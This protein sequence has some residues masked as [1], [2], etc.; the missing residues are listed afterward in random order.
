[1]VKQRLEKDFAEVLKRSPN[2]WFQKFYH[3]M[4]LYTTVPADYIVLSNSYSVLVECKECRGSAFVFDRLTQLSSLKHFISQG[5]TF[6]SYVLICFWRKNRKSS[7]YWCVPISAM[8]KFIDD[9]GKKSANANDF[10]AL[11][12]QYSIKLDDISYIFI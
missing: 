6:K 1:M 10:L 7:L 5:I 11:L 9:V 4:G 8:E 3:V 12:P 2:L